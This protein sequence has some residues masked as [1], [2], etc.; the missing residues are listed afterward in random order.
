MVRQGGWITNNKSFA[1]SGA[2]FGYLPQSKLAISTVTTYT[3]GAFDAEGNY[4]NASV[5]VFTQLANT[6]SPKMPIPS[7]P[8][9]KG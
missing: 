4:P 9:Q 7:P 3:A 8:A 5:D 1:G 6:L 2:A